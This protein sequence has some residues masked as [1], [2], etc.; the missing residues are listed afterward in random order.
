M[1]TT[2]VTGAGGV[3]GQILWRALG[4]EHDLRGIDRRRGPQIRRAD[5]TKLKSVE[6]EFDGVDNVVDLAGLPEVTTPWGEVWKNNIPAT[7]NALEASRRAG[8][9][10]F[11]FASSNH[12]TG[13]YEREQPY[14]RIVSGDIEGLSPD[15]IPHIRTTDPIR[16]DSP[17]AVGKALGEAAGRYY[18]EEFDLSVVCL[19]I[20]TVKAEDRPTQPRE[21]A[22]L[23][24]HEDLA[25]LVDCALRAPADV[26]FGIYYG[27]SANTWRFWDVANAQ[28]IGWAPR[29]DAERFRPEI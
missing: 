2:L 9:R 12:V 5:M 8:V 7:M 11:V 19:R 17:Y 10:R 3:V 18:A 21:L 24:T 15:E 22:T 20:G 25:A 26:R 1:P 4:E 13:L 27:V 28:E 14:A 29:D 23:L 6:R 16:P